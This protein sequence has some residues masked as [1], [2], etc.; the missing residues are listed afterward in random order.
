M[1]MSATFN[2]LL[3]KLI[4]PEVHLF[5]LT[6]STYLVCGYIGLLLGVLLAISLAMYQGLLLWVMG[7]AVLT[8]VLTFLGLAMFVKILTGEEI[9]VCYHHQI[10]VLVTM[11]LVLWLLGQPVL[12]YVT[13]NMLGV[14][15]FIAF[16]RIGCLMVGC[17]HGR[18][19][20]CGV[21]YRQE[22]ANVG[23]TNYFVGVRLFPIQAVASLLLFLN[24]LGGSIM[25]LLGQPG[26][27]LAWYALVY[28]LG[29]FYI[30]FFRG[31][32]TR[33]YRWGFSEAQWTALLVAVAVTGAGLIGVLPFR[34]WYGEIT[35]VLLV[36]MLAV[37]LKRHWQRSNQYQLLHPHHVREVA[38]VINQVAAAAN[39]TPIAMDI[40]STSAG[41]RISAS[42]SNDDNGPVVHY[43][44]SSANGA[45]SQESAGILADLIVQ[46]KHPT[47]HR[48]LVTGNG[49]IFHLLVHP[50]AVGGKHE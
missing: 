46:L 48:Q 41:I 11:S 12:P 38:Q 32:P 1:N 47:Q 36:T 5:G 40:Q 3:D 8:A 34:T 27:A 4:R 7:V 6:R 30:E 9:I 16:G 49:G 20:H 43:A 35:A 17:C 18:P 24:V 26:L 31:D 25:V 29:R 39:G 19:H 15:V 10:A 13:P 33:S 42:T 50:A 44:L 22:H 23:F 37:T 2:R 21:C 45:I 28:S 14:G